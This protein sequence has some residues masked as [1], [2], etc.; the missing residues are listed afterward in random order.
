MKNKKRLTTIATIAVL[1]A[2]AFI[3]LASHNTSNG[4]KI[5]AVFPLT[6]DVASYGRAAQRGIDLGV[7]EINAAGGIGG[8]PIEIL[9]EDDQNQ[10][11]TAINALR[12]LVSVDRVQ[13][14]LGSAASSVTLA[15]CPVAKEN[16]VVL[17]T[18]ISSSPELTTQ[19][20]DFFFRVCPS[21]V[22]QAKLMAEWLHEE[23]F[24]RV[25]LL[26]VNNSWG[27]GLRV[28]FQTAFSTHDG[29]II[30]QEACNEGDL[31]LRTQ[32]SKLKESNPDVVYAITYGREGGA[33]LRQAQELGLSVPV[34]GA[35]VWGSSELRETAGDTARGVRIY[36]PASFS[37]PR[38]ETFVRQFKERN[39]EDPDVYAAYAYDMVHIVAQAIR[40][41]ES[42]GITVRDALVDTEY[43]G[44]TGMT[45]FDEHGDVIGKGFERRKLK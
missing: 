26:Y 3:Y 19:G 38:Y 24:S 10:P 15:L 11:S 37:G 9:Y 42:E 17:V 27:Q 1:A 12:K 35:D 13:A 23:K 39:G 2:A 34:F 5:G 32:I 36:A 25:A 43:D 44:V 41:S 40:T 28:E 31:D 8:Q 45:R 4:V 16:Q 29:T 20:G 30:A 6:G 21:D 14:V 22:L 7:A 18:P 33:F